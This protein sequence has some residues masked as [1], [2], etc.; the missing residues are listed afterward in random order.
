[1]LFFLVVGQCVL[2]PE[3]VECIEHRLGTAEQQVPKLRLTVGIETNDLTIEHTAAASEVMDQ[4]FAKAGERSEHIAI[5]GH[6]P[7][8]LVVGIEQ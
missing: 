8:A 3:N 4:P 6:E 7:H 5:P 1:V 2:I